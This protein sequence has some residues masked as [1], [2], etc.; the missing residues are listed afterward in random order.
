[1]KLLHHDYCELQKYKKYAN[2]ISV[3][4]KVKIVETLKYDLSYMKYYIDIAIQKPYNNFL[5]HQM[6]LNEKVINYNILDPVILYNFSI[7][8]DFIRDHMKKLCI[9]IAKLF[10]GAGHAITRP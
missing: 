10:V 9:F 7:K 6:T 3:Y 8:F 1:M 4:R 5:D 2:Y